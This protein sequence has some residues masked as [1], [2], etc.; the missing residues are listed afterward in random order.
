MMNYDRCYD[1]WENMYRVELEGA[2]FTDNKVKLAN[3]FAMIA[4]SERQVSHITES[5]TVPIS[6][7]DVKFYKNGNFIYKIG[8]IYG[9]GKYLNFWRKGIVPDS[10]QEEYYDSSTGTYDGVFIPRS[11][12]KVM[13]GTEEDVAG[14]TLSW[15]MNGERF[16][17]KI[18][19]VYDDFPRNCS[20]RNCIYRY[21]PVADENNVSNYNYYSYVKLDDDANKSYV[22]D[23]LRKQLVTDAC[24]GY[25]DLR[26]EYEKFFGDTKVHLRPLHEA[27]FSKI[28]EISDHGDQF[29][30]NI[31]L[32]SA[33]L[34]I[35]ITNVNYMNFSLAEA[36]FRMKNINTRRVFGASRWHL[37]TELIVENIMVSI[38]AFA[39]C[40]GVIYLLDRF[41][42]EDIRPH[43]NVSAVLLTFA[44]AMFIGIISGTYPAYFA[45]SSK[46]A[47]AM[48][49]MKSIP[50]HSR[51][52]RNIRILFQ[53]FISFIAIES[54]CILILQ[55]LFIKT[56]DYGYEK[57][58][59]LFAE[60]NSV[61]ANVNAESMF[62]AIEAIDGVQNVSSGSFLIGTNDRYMMWSRAAY[63]GNG[64]A[65]FTILPV[66]MKYMQTMGIEIIQGRRFC[67]ADS[68]G[69]YIV[70]EAALRKYPW[71]KLG[72]SIFDQGENAYPVV[73]VCR[74]VQFS[75]LRLDNNTM[76]LAF[77][78]I[79]NDS[80]IS[81][82]RKTHNINIRVSDDADMNVVTA[83]VEKTYGQMFP[84]GS[85]LELRTLNDEFRS[86]YNNEFIYL[87]HT[88]MFA[89]I[90]MVITMIGVSCTI[91]FECEFHRKEIAVRK[92][93]GA[94]MQNIMMQKFPLFIG[95]LIIAFF[96]SIPFSILATDSILG[97]FAKVSPYIWIAFPISFIFMAVMTFTKILVQRYRYAKEKPVNAINS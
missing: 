73:G 44:A 66:G 7:T 28:D 15:E 54:V 87:I 6:A 65:L 55:A 23:A 38:M 57:D 85:Q 78:Y 45:T 32:I 71:I 97:S 22:E 89:I 25:E 35:V 2:M 24:Q 36:P 88:L 75:S 5:A 34:V 14:R 69:A 72:N 37:M 31:L 94:S 30:V 10:L 42:I 82:N 70:N 26:P 33:I 76:P 52:L 60:V 9:G 51:R 96:L 79:A 1:D 62:D 86:I 21:Q 90:Y 80:S 18:I 40:L 19:N 46:P 11:F 29:L 16:S 64:T 68:L 17:F 92:V 12:A 77:L 3:V 43:S 93:F 61:D 39:V 56:T 8:Y 49:G 48:K 83:N 27:Y 58:H 74:D 91:M 67:K 13:F 50:M 53:I 84:N 20:V 41:T 95:I 59:L 4:K 63:K 47:L 81:K